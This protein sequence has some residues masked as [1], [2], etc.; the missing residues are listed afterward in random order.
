ML[1]GHSSCS[2]YLEG[3][4]A[5]LNPAAQEVLLNEV[6]QVF[7]D[8]DNSM[9]KKFPTKQEVKDD[10][11]ESNLNAAPDTDGITSQLY[12]DHWKVIGDS[13]HQVVSAIMGGE[14]PTTSQKTSLMVFG[15]KPKK[16]NSL[17]PSDKR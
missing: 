12:H 15:C 7:T 6:Q 14:S 4:V 11:F 13:D 8:K 5:N 2:W 1:E 17:L 16:H 3:H 10:L 9:L